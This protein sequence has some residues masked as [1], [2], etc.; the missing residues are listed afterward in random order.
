MA[1]HN[2]SRQFILLSVASLVVIL[3][4]AILILPVQAGENHQETETYCLSCHSNPDLSMQLP[5]GEKLSLF[6][7]PDVIGQ[8]VHSPIGIECEACHTDIKTYP[9]P[10]L[11]AANLREL[12][13]TY[14]LVC[15]KCH[16]SNYEK[17]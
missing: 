11:K 9:H 10:E 5:S 8:S 15:E 16:T 14:Y 17:R 2:H 3:I 6:I 1:K 12:S 13:R 7:S 4:L